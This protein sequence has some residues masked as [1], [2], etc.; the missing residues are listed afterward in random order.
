[1]DWWVCLYFFG[2]L[3]LKVIRCMV[4]GC[5][6]YMYGLCILSVVFVRFMCFVEVIDG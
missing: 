4:I 5:L 2:I 3:F 6:Y 1:M